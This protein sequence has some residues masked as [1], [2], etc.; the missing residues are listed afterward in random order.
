[1]ETGRIG[2]T[3]LANTQKHRE[4]RR[5]APAKTAVLDGPAPRRRRRGDRPGRRRSGPARNRKRAARR[6][7]GRP[8][9][10]R[11]GRLRRLRS[12]AG[13]LRQDAT[14]ALG[15]I[16][17]G[18]DWPCLAP[19]GSPR[20]CPGRGHRVRAG[21]DRLPWLRRGGPRRPPRPLRHRRR[22]RAGTRQLTARSRPGHPHALTLGPR[23]TPGTSM[24]SRAACTATMSDTTTPRT[25]PWNARN[26]HT[27]CSS[28]VTPPRLS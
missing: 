3:I 26:A 8:G 13:D 4:S 1:M 2:A 6:G 17:A 15:V 12:R 21:R 16:T 9:R 19:C 5:N 18:R 20:R 23:H 27:L 24:R 14:A 7:A 10:D 25:P 11:A 28:T 22:P